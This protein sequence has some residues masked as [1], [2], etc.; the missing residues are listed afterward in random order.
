MS[1]SVILSTGFPLMVILSPS[2]IT[3][4]LFCFIIFLSSDVCSIGSPFT[5]ILSSS[6]ITVV[7][8]AFLPLPVFLIIT[9]SSFLAFG[10]SSFYCAND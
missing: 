4:I 5:V 1:S 8:S 7:F 6:T 10:A 9:F 3:V 2:T